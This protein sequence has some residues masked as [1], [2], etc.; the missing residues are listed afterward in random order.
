MENGG[1]VAP[2]K[3]WYQL[4]QVSVDVDMNFKSLI[5]KE[6]EWNYRINARYADLVHCT[7]SNC[8]CR[9]LNVGVWMYFLKNK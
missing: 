5:L 3:P 7:L 1:D 6:N 4:G 9:W 8:D 2:D